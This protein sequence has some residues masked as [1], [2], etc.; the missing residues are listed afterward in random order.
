MYYVFITLSY[1]FCKALTYVYIHKTSALACIKA[2]GT[3]LEYY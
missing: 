3:S 1:N 2:N